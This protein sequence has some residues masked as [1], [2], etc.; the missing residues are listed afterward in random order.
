LSSEA[1]PIHDGGD[2]EYFGYERRGVNK[3]LI[4]AIGA[5]AVLSFYLSL[6]VATRVDGVLTPGNSLL[7]GIVQGGCIVG[8]DVSDPDVATPEQRINILVMGLDQR[9]DEP[10]NQPYRTDSIVIFSIDPYTKTAGAFSIPRDTRVAIP[11]EGED[12]TY[13]RINEAYEMGEFGVGGY[14]TTGQ[15]AKLAKDVL[16]YNF[17][18]QIDYYAVINW[19]SFI[20]IVD[21]LGGV[22]IDVPEY[23][24][25]PAYATCSFC[26]EYYP[27][28]FEPGVQDMD[29]TRA[30]EYARLRKSDNDY[31]RIERQQLVMRAI[32]SKATTLNLLDIGKLRGMYNTYHDSIKT[33]M[34]D[35][36]LP[37]LAKLGG[38]VGL[39]NVRMISAAPAMFPCPA[40]I[41]GGAAELLW[42]IDEF[43]RLK[44]LV[45]TDKRVVTESAKIDVLNGTNTRGLATT[46]GRQLALE[47][48]SVIDIKPDEE[49]D[50]LLWDT[51]MI[52]DV[53][54]NKPQT[55]GLIKGEL[56]LT[57]EHVLTAAEVSS[58]APDLAEFLDTTSDIIV[59]LGADHNVTAPPVY[60][61]DDPIFEP[62]PT[63]DPIYEEPIFE[64]DPTEEPIFEPD[65]TE[66]PAP[67]EEP[68]ITDPPAE[69]L[70]PE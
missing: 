1:P 52:I 2:G 24:Y 56:G 3:G 16:A 70:A 7:P 48:L 15:G 44:D 41:C 34:P 12:W 54:G 47:G 5:F 40:S 30:L 23:V 46:F 13:T 61:P 25:D 39:E 69:E 45:F 63:E 58:L 53:T 9:L 55:V 37:G 66:E 17:D 8:C 32:A 50:G 64:P 51:T 57:D 10:D 20:N 21:D 33:D 18:I 14:P 11:Y 19:N 38:Q 67:T 62:E 59:V 65:P 4:F 26:G 27:V 60:V 31:K 36:Q 49:A 22:T 68:V 43:N 29:G 28:E 6:I 42:D 35:S